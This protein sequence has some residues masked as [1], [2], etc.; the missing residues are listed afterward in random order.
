M[1]FW[2]AVSAGRR[3]HAALLCFLLVILT[4]ENLA[5][6]KDE[7]TAQDR[8]RYGLELHGRGRWKEALLVFAETVAKFGINE[9]MDCIFGAGLSYNTLGDLQVGPYDFFWS[10]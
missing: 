2:H 3:S 7:G 4:Y 9:S 1:F 5:S 6:S 10:A 8:C